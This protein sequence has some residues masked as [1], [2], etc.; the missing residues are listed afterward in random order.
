MRTLAVCL[1]LCPLGLIAQDGAAGGRGGRGGA[2]AGPPKNLKIL[3]ADVNIQQVM[4]GIR[5]A[6]GV[7][8]N[9]CHGP[10]GAGGRGGGAPGGPPAPIDFASDENPKKLMARNMMRMVDDL[11]SGP[12]NGKMQ[13]TCYTC[14]RGEATPKM[15]AP[16]ADAGGGGRG[17]GGRGGGQPPP[18]EK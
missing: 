16:A 4:G 10:E 11:N 1:L 2:P 18:E 17:R 12:L 5:V 8:C 9:F 7:Q 13:V 15:D 6:L 14:H 3:P